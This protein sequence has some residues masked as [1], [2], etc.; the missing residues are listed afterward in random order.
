MKD[1]EREILTVLD[2]VQ[3]GHTTGSVSQLC[4]HNTYGV[5]NRRVRSGAFRSWLVNL[6]SQGL[7]GK[8][9]SKLPTVWI[10]TNEGKRAL[11]GEPR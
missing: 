10:I 1:I 7:V 11:G 8:L 5:A 4:T 6:E 3:G 2:D 9:D